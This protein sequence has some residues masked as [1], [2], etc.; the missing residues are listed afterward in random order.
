M[1]AIY[2]LSNVEK[3]LKKNNAQAVIIPD[4]N[5]LINN[6]D[7]FI[8]KTPIENPVFLLSDINTTEI[9]HLACR[10]GV[11]GS[12]A[13]LVRDSLVKLYD[14]GNP[15]EGIQIPGVGWFIIVK[16]P[17]KSI[18]QEALGQIQIIADTLKQSDTMLLFLTRDCNET[19]NRVPVICVTSDTYLYM[20]GKPHVPSLL[21]CKKQ[22]PGPELNEWFGKS[23]HA[24]LNVNWDKELSEVQ[25]QIES[26][27][28]E[29]ELTLTSKKYVKSWHY[30]EYSKNIV[31]G[32]PPDDIPE[33]LIEDI[34]QYKPTDVIIA[35]G[36]GRIYLLENKEVFFNWRVPYKNVLSEELA[37][38]SIRGEPC[39][40]VIRDDVPLL[41]FMMDA[42]DLDFF[43]KEDEISQEIKQEL[44]HKL[45]LCGT[46][47]S[48]SRVGLPTFQSPLC[49]AET[50]FITNIGKKRLTD[51]NS[52][53]E[54]ETNSSLDT[55]EGFRQ[56]FCNLI[57]KCDED[58]VASLI[59]EMTSCW[60][61]G[62][63][64][65]TRIK[66]A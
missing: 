48:L 21:L 1:P 20:V 16:A 27:T 35:E 34:T 62:H 38:D 12:S 18:Y 50:Y 47:W 31:F 58:E 51:S 14:L 24:M 56:L 53:V 28:V 41:L 25:K 23:H 13:R 15:T 42:Q 49:M 64:I 52:E 61:I 59:D 32:Q 9:C 45:S 29:V 19:V 3:L 39:K 26:S 40:I 43:G 2:D 37:K 46:P 10:Q 60:N 5:V 22:F 36:Y 44:L 8:W 66:T 65:R 63:T 17:S 11:E 30:N 33:E 7:I 4:T 57:S 55:Y 54:S 6:P